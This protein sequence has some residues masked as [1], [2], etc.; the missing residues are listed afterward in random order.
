MKK[1]FKISLL[2][3]L[4]SLSLLFVS[5]EE[6]QL[7]T[8]LPTELP[9]NPETEDKP[10]E[11]TPTNEVPT[12]T[13]NLESQFNEL[14]KITLS[15]D[16]VYKLSISEK[17]EETKYIYFNQ[18]KYF[19]KLN[20]TVTDKK[21]N[22]NFD[23]LFVDFLEVNFDLTGDI[24]RTFKS[25]VNTTANEYTVI[26]TLST[27][28]TEKEMVCVINTQEQTYLL[29]NGN[30]N[31]LFQKDVLYSVADFEKEFENKPTEEIPTD[32][33][34]L[35]KEY[36][37]IFETGIVYQGFVDYDSTQLS[38]IEQIETSEMLSEKGVDLQKMASDV[39]LEL[40][41]DLLA[42][43]V[44]LLLYFENPFIEVGNLYLEI[45]GING[46]I[47]IYEEENVCF[48][49]SLNEHE[50]IIMK[51]ADFTDKI[52]MIVINLEYNTNL[53][54]KLESYYSVLNNNTPT[55]ELDPDI[56]DSVD[57]SL[58]IT[59]APSIYT[60]EHEKYWILFYVNGCSDC[61]AI[62]ETVLNYIERDKNQFDYPIY[63]VN[64]LDENL[65]DII[66]DENEDEKVLNTNSSHQL[67]IK[68]VPILALLEENTIT[69]IYTTKN[70]FEEV[71]KFKNQTS[72]SNS[73]VYVEMEGETKINFESTNF[74]I[75]D[76]YGELFCSDIYYNTTVTSTQELNVN[77]ELVKLN[78]AY[79]LNTDLFT[80]NGKMS[81]TGNNTSP[82]ATFIECYA[83]TYAYDEYVSNI[84][85]LKSI[86]LIIGDKVIDLSTLNPVFSVDYWYS[87]RLDFKYGLFAGTMPDNA[88]TPDGVYVIKDAKLDSK[89][90]K[91]STTLKYETEDFTLEIINSFSDT[92]ESLI[93]FKLLYNDG[94]FNINLSGNQVVETTETEQTNFNLIPSLESS[95]LT[96]VYY[97][98]HKE[99]TED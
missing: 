48:E 6:T 25:I 43:N 70:E 15:N 88:Y 75:Y 28:E 26:Y 77:T 23:E 10:T 21:T 38:S 52:G 14:I 73:N 45:F 22:V 4:F 44:T 69:K 83:N 53:E 18:N 67:A 30:K 71:L 76:V 11:K 13:V 99:T 81:I 17:D 20:N 79:D 7:P 29:Q 82:N 54:A 1:L 16:I 74:R 84:N 86:N 32:T 55:E 72:E 78:V 98:K 96:A 58:K 65:N 60:K 89:L 59:S 19:I 34:V 9:T 36:I 63:L 66:A 24:N 61:D 64:V 33:P 2:S 80:T 95:K 50:T 57:N 93:S 3:I 27:P 12:E 51:V 5:C 92:E 46:S 39:S 91:L 87:S 40:R 62:I 94:I 35:E 8:E 56:F 49:M 42:E 37:N 41:N 31:V 97:H 90:N 68:N 85:F 47:V